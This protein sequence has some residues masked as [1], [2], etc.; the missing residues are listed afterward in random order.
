MCRISLFI[1]P[2]RTLHT[3]T[4]GIKYV[5][6]HKRDILSCLLNSFCLCLRME[7]GRCAR[8]QFGFDH[9][10]GLETRDVRRQSIDLVA[11]GAISLG[12]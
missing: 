12:V 6:D 8:Y 10:M 7:N 5:F 2:T 9:K 1:Q 3:Q 11:R 4:M